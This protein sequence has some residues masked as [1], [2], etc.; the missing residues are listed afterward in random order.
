M[1]FLK[2]CEKN[3]GRAPPFGSAQ[4]NTFYSGSRP[5]NDVLDSF[6]IVHQ[7]E[8]ATTVFTSSNFFAHYDQLK[9]VLTAFAS[10][11][12]LWQPL[13]LLNSLI[14]FTGYQLF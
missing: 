5:L 11:H 1:H 10:C 13:Q 2:S 3:L 14:A 7:L 12:K 8:E 6:D 4:K 9:N